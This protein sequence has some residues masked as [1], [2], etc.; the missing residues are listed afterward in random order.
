MALIKKL[1]KIEKQRNTVHD[2][3]ESTYTIFTDFIGNKFLQIDT[4]GSTS[5]QFRGKVSQSIQ[6]SKE[7]ARELLNIISSQLLN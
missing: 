5:R 4:Y 1:E 6:L 7:S 2:E 3:V